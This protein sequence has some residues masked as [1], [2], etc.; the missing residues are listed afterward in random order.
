MFGGHGIYLDDLFVALVLDGQLYLK[1][2]AAA[3][4]FAAAGGQAFRYQR[5]G[6]AAS[7]GFW[8]VPDDALDSPEGMRPW[9]ALALQAA[10]SARAAAAARPK[11][12]RRTPRAGPPR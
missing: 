1:A 11:R 2:G 8:T 6:Q 3:P 5:L 10:L 12:P 7:L 4:R 9:A